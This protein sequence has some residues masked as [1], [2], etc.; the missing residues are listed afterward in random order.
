ME[1]MNHNSD[2]LLS[3]TARESRQANKTILADAVAK[4]L[5]LPR[6]TASLVLEAVLGAVSE[7]LPR[8]GKLTIKG[9][10]AFER[11][12]RKGRAYTHPMTR[13]SIKV[14]DKE[15]IIF[16]ASE[17]LNLATRSDPAQREAGSGTDA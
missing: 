15:T 9:F 13:E 8:R 6:R 14:A 16:R 17:Q 1:G 3:T 4:E 12:V 2:S 10:G 11:K 7:L 5:N